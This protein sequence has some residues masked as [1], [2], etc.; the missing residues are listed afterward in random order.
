MKRD[1]QLIIGYTDAL[2]I[3]CMKIKNYSRVMVMALTSN[4]VMPVW[5]Q[6]GQ[7]YSHALAV[8]ALKDDCSFGVLSSQHHWWWT[9]INAS[10]L[11]AGTRYTPKDVFETFPM[12][13]ATLKLR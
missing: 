10:S 8:F 2:L 13:E 7:I 5:V 1:Q 9:Q 4:A 12:C 6:S 11:G 3:K